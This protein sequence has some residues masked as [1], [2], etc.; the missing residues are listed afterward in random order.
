MNS[1]VVPVVAW[2]LTRFLPSAPV[3]R[4]G[5]FVALLTPCID[6]VIPSP[7]SPAGNGVA[8]GPDARGDAVRRHRLALPEGYGLTPAVVVTQPLV[9]LSGVV[10]LTRTV[11]AVLVPSAPRPP[12]DAVGSD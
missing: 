8:P 6:Y 12:F 1:L 9:E 3:V 7:N 2:G 4:V 5:A 11:P 10:V